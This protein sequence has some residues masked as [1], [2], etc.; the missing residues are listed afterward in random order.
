MNEYTAEQAQRWA[1]WKQANTASERR[2]DK[3]MRMFG[4]TALAVLIAI[5]AALV[6]R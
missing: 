6:G 3:R 4:L 5:T 2:G 1:E